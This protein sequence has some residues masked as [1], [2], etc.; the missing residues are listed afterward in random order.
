MLDMGAAFFATMALVS[1]LMAIRRPNWWYV[2]AAF[3]VLGALQKAAIGLFLVVFFL[4]FLSLT[5]RWHGLSYQ[6]IQADR[7]F[8]ISAWFAFLG[9]I[10]WPLM[11]GLL[12][13]FVAFEET[14]SQQAFKRFMPT[15]KAGEIRAVYD[16]NRLIIGGEPVVRWL[17]IAALAWLPMRLKRPELLPLPMIFGAY[18]VAMLLADGHVTAR[19]TL[20]FLPMLAASVSCVAVSLNERQWISLLVIVGIAAAASGPVRAQQSLGLG[21]REEYRQQID[22]LSHVGAAMKPEERLVVCIASGKSR[23]VPALASYFAAGDQPFTRLERPERKPEIPAGDG[24]IRGICTPA[25]LE[26]FAHHFRGIEVV[27]ELPPY[28]MWTADGLQ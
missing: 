24:P 17:G 13:D 11:Q 7:R 12:H 3:V 16:L 14:F 8:R 4:L 2:C 10:A 1:V 18:V 20:I 26:S 21:M 28:V 23:I 22:I 5:S 6:E 25:D 27:E 15:H 9:T 19:Y